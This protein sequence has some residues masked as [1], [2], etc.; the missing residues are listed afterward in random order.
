M[1]ENMPSTTTGVELLQQGGAQ[2]KVEMKTDAS[3]EA[4]S[5][6]RV[7]LTEIIITF[8]MLYSVYG[9]YMDV[10]TVSGWSS[11]I[12]KLQYNTRI[13]PVVHVYSSE[14]LEKDGY[15]LSDNQNVS[16]NNWVT[17]YCEDSYPPLCHPYDRDNANIV[18]LCIF[19]SVNET[20]VSN[21][22]PMKYLDRSFVCPS[23]LDSTQ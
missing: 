10:A 19:G 2:T 23:A 16:P 4:K 5:Y 22:L 17:F 8:F 11:K 13:A 7:L 21:T 6:V 14:N 15:F 9:C 12:E 18:P 1:S 3:G 20:L